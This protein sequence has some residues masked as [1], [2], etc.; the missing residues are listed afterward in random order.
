[1]HDEFIKTLLQKAIAD[2][3]RLGI[4]ILEPAKQKTYVVDYSGPNVAKP[5]HV[6]HIR[7]TVIGNALTRMLRFSGH[8]AITDNHL[9]DWGTQFGM[10]IYG[11]KNFLDKDAYRKNPV[12]ELSRLYRLVRQKMDEEEDGRRQTADGSRE[13][14]TV[15]PTIHQETAKLHTGDA[16]NLKIWQEVLPHSQDEINRI[17]ARLKISFDHTLGESFYQPMLADV[18]EDLQK[19]NADVDPK[20]RRCLSLRHNGFGNGQ[21]S[22]RHFQAGCDFVCRR[23]PAVAAL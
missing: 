9:G 20:V 2:E 18:V 11:Y 23:F 10:I 5:M 4:P 21:V 17:Y 16:E 6:G 14:A 1:L 12:E 15:S 13:L 3:E 19:R 7:S 22:A 8:H